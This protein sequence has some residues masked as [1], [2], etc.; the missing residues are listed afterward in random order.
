MYL[1][2]YECV[3]TVQSSTENVGV[4]TVGWCIGEQN[5][6]SHCFIRNIL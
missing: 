1:F 6:S 2:K 5:L 3:F 4:A